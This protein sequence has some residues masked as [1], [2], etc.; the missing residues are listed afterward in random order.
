MRKANGMGSVCK[1]GGKRRKPWIA[2]VSLGY[3]DDGRM[4]RKIVGTYRTRKEAEQGLAEYLY[5]PESMR[6]KAGAESTSMTLEEAWNGWLAQASLAKSTLSGYKSYY[7]KL[8]DYYKLPLDR[9]TTEQLQE[10]VNLGKSY[11]QASTIKKVLSTIYSYAYAHEG[12]KASKVKLLDYVKLPKNVKST[13]HKPF[14]DEEIQKCFEQKATAALIFIFTGL[15]ISELRVLD[16]SDVDYENQYLTVRQ[17]KT[18]AGYREVPIPDGLIPWIK[19]YFNHKKYSTNRGFIVHHWKA[20]ILENH[21][22]HDGRHTYIT[23][24]TK[25]G[26]PEGIIKKLAGH[27]DSVTGAVYTH[28][29]LEEKLEAV[30]QAFSKYF[31]EIEKA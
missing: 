1:I 24:L 22:T 9:I 21:T 30:N 2:R 25:A 27:T 16:E 12:C 23:L 28:I 14:T 18:S 31:Q 29:T 5:L 13:L 7:K 10:M 17:S 19:E 26:V 4:Q 15:R 11:G 3:D 6:A 8:N 20:S